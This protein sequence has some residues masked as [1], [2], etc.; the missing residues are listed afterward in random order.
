MSYETLQLTV[1]DTIAWITLNRPERLNSFDMQLGHELYDVLQDVAKNH[2]IRLVVI[3]GTGK[4]FCGGGDVKEMHAAED[5]SRF[6]RDLTRAIHRCVIEIRSM[7]KPVIA[8]VNGAAFGAGLSLALACDMVIAVKDA[9]MSTAF[10]GIGLAP[11]CGTQFVTKILGYQKS[12]EYIL[13]SKTFSAD[14]GCRLGLI[15]KVVEAEALDAAVEEIISIFRNLPPIAVGKAK[16][17]INKSLDNDMISHL[18]L[19]SKTAAW[20]AGTKDFAEGVAAFV[21]KRKPVFKG[22]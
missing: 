16:M 9:K 19:E 10:I 11:G 4:G 12:C 17:L 7:E 8:A 15:N 1:K 18:E 13:T 14:E 22:K 3:K 5:K 2:E 21:E 20:S 6:L